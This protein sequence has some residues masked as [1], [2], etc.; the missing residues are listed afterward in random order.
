M[1]FLEIESKPQIPLAELG[2]MSLYDLVQ[3]DRNFMVSVCNTV[4][5]SDTIAIR[6]L[7]Q[8]CQKWMKNPNKDFIYNTIESEENPLLAFRKQKSGWKMESVWQ[9]FECDRV[10]SNEEVSDFISKII[11]HVA[12]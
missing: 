9:K 4:F 11:S 6:E 10:F 7:A 3:D 5:F 2:K 1:L 8:Y 12:K